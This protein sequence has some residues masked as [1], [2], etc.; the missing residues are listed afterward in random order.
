MLDHLA[1]AREEIC[2]SQ[3]E[4]DLAGD[5]PGRRL[6]WCTPPHASFFELFTLRAYL[7]FSL[8]PDMYRR[9]D[10]HLPLG[11]VYLARK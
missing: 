4:Q 8:P 7:K 6:F 9:I 3:R 1:K 5:T 11:A 2:A 10:W